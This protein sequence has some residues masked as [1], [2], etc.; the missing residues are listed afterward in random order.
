CGV[1]DSLP[2]RAVDLGVS[3][4]Q[5]MASSWFD[6]KPRPSTA[7]KPAS[8][9]GKERIAILGGGVGA[10]AAAFALTQAPDWKERYDITVYQNGWRLGGKGASGRDASHHQRIEEHGIHVWFGFYDNAFRMM[11]RCYEGLP[12][13]RD[14]VHERP[15]L[16][17]F[18]PQRFQSL[19]R[20]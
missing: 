16:W 15:I 1:A 3:A 17:G 18:E 12:S 6:L 8:S 20:R 4:V 9:G 11:R 2:G 19:M 5:T 14:E 13:I 10:I 7:V